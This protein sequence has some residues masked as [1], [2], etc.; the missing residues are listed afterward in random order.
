MSNFCGER[1]I[2][3]L[4]RLWNFGPSSSDDQVRLFDLDPNHGNAFGR[5]HHETRGNHGRKNSDGD[6]GVLPLVVTPEPGSRTLLLFGL[7][8]LGM[9]VYRRNA[10]RNA[11]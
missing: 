8:G 9:T 7:A 3:D 1:K 4:D 10:P 6:I 2:S 5:G 11:I